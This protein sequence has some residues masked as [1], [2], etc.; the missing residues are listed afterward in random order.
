MEIVMDQ[1][2]YFG[3]PAETAR[4]LFLSLAALLVALICLVILLAVF[5]RSPKKRRGR[6]DRPGREE[7]AVR[8]RRE[9]VRSSGRVS[10]VS[11]LPPFREDRCCVC[12]QGLEAG[13]KVLFR[14]DAGEEARL[15]LPC[16]RML[17]ALGKSEDLAQVLDAREYMRSRCGV[18]DPAVARQLRK[19]LRAS[20]D[21]VYKG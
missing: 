3:L 7:S 2:R 1:T 21:F 16:Y 12:G 14:T 6:P 19:F 17:H 5:S 18:V 11:T 4:W 13:Y 10:S 20:D 8:R 15:D 9:D